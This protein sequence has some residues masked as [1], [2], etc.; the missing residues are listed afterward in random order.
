MHSLPSDTSA[1][2]SAENG[3]GA[4]A[5][6]SLEDASAMKVAELREE[7]EKRGLDTKGLKA[8]LVER[9]VGES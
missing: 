5:K 3:A 8:A 7:L 9:L 4:H 6:V 1:A 2:S